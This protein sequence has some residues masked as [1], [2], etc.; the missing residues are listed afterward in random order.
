VHVCVSPPSW[1]R[2]KDRQPVTVEEI[3][4]VLVFFMLAGIVQKRS[5]RLYLSWN[6]LVATPTFVSVMLFD[7]FE[8]ICRFPA[9]HWQHFQEYIWKTEKIIKNQ[10]I[11]TRL[12]SKF[13]ILYLPQHF[14]SVVGPFMVW[15]GHLSF[16]QYLPLKSL[17]L[18]LKRLWTVGV[19]F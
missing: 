8:S 13:Q 16:K 10:S 14:I 6:Q 4:I 9:L 18:K 17:H 11:I 7:I 12:D 1:S 2:V 3:C 15:K 19:R 5:L